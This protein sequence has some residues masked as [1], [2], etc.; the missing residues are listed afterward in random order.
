MFVLILGVCFFVSLALWFCGSLVFCL[1]NCLPVWCS[2][3]CFVLAFW[4]VVLWLFACFDVSYFAS[5]FVC[6]FAS[7][8][9]GLLYFQFFL[10]LLFM[11]VLCFVAVVFFF[12]LGWFLWF[13]GRVLLLTY[14][15]VLCLFIQL[16]LC[17]FFLAVWLCA[18]LIVSEEV[19]FHVFACCLT[20]AASA[21]CRSSGL[22]LSNC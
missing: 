18:P 17:V 4:L 5:L 2:A 11:T 13:L 6:L 22:P 16:D 12:V 3:S 8:L 15:M 21:S 10:F 7:W 9:L 19:F 20:A 14:C 1:F